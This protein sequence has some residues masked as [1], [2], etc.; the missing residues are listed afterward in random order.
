MAIRLLIGLGN[1]GSEYAGTRHNIGADWL[2][3]LASRHHIE[4]K[5]ESRFHGLVGRGQLLGRDVRLLI[6]TTYMNR[7]GLAAAALARFFKIEVAEVFV[8][9][10]EMAFDPGTLR[11]KVGGGAGGHNGIR[12]LLSSFGNQDGFCRLRI[13][14]GH[15]GS[16]SKVTRYLTSNRMPDAERAEVEAVW[17]IDEV[18]RDVLAGDLEPAMN[19]LHAPV[20]TPAESSELKTSRKD[21]A[22]KPPRSPGD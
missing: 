15:P 13:G 21:T 12:D 19:A 3:D 4:L 14:V 6:P 5:A 7:S 10:D 1:P 20:S 9:Y 22:D 8:A 17:Q 2:A 16:A 18:L 11:L